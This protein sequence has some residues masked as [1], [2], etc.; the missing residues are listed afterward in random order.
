MMQAL[1]LDAG[2]VPRVAQVRPDRP[3][4][5][6]VHAAVGGELRKARA[7]EH[8]AKSAFGRRIDADAEQV[9]GKP[10]LADTMDAVGVVHELPEL[11]QRHHGNFWRTERPGVFAD[12]G[13]ARH[14]QVIH[15]Q[16]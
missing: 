11:S 1:V 14:H 16:Q 8:Q 6:I 9:Q 3:S 13:V 5:G 15:G 7:V 4:Q 10:G 2:P 12:D